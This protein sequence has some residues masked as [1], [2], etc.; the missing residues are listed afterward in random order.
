[1]I[2]SYQRVKRI[3]QN[4]QCKKA[5]LQLLE[6]HKRRLEHF[7]TIDV[8]L[9]IG[10]RIL[11]VIEKSQS[12]APTNL[13]NLIKNVYRMVIDHYS[14]EVGNHIPIEGACKINMLVQCYSF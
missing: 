9:Q 3:G 7:M 6:Y 10:Q 4:L 1:M 14:Q 12:N 2:S 8:K 5:C 13:D 11:H